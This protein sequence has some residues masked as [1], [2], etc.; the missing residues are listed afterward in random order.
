M[1]RGGSQ[2]HGR[3][4]SDRVQGRLQEAWLLGHIKNSTHVPETGAG[5]YMFQPS[6]IAE[7]LTGVERLCSSMESLTMTTK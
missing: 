3:N 1:R 4:D 7:G 5:L 2:P 6:H